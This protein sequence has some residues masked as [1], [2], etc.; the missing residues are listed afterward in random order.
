MLLNYKEKTHCICCN[1]SD[2]R[3]VLDLGK[4][5]LANSYHKL[6]EE[7]DEFPLGLNLCTNCFH[8]QL[9]HIVNPDLLF[10]HYL[11]VSG[12]SATS[13]AYFDWFVR[14]VQEYTGKQNGT[15]LDI[16]CNDGSQLDYFQKHGW[17]TFGVEPAVNLY[18]VSKQKHSVI[19]D[20]FKAPIFDN[21]TFD[22]IV[23]QNVFAHLEETKQ[24]LDDCYSM[25]TDDSYLF[26]QTSQAEL[27][28]NNQYDTIY[29]EHLSFFNINSMNEL[30]KRTQ[31]YLIDVIKSHIHGISYIFV[32]SK[33]NTNSTYVQN[34]IAVEREKG[35]LNLKTYE[36]YSKNV[37]Y[38]VKQFG[39][40]V[41]QFRNEGYKI[42]GYGAAAKGMTVL[43]FT[44]V[45]LD[46]IID[47]NPLKHNL[48][49][50]GMNI[51]ILPQSALEEYSLDDKIVFVPL[52]WN[53]F[54]E[55]K[56]KILKIRQSKNDIFLMYFPYIRIV[57]SNTIL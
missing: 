18:E 44:N 22:I 36:E 11:Y 10:K 40:T 54:N 7:L 53:F 12:T 6:G 37:N 43:N 13:H 20:Y 30:V 27:I 47:D 9:S 42:I 57:E 23:A 34:H 35:L 29:H 14:F 48:Y 46:L 16:A 21:K 15:V 32:I 1:S 17:N 24:F 8:L 2:L 56:S 5:P 39:D 52:A 33:K 25:M 28:N 55:I 51:Q 26:I 4:Q 19:C 41:R 50:P 49:T 3:I 45:K 31:L 38:S